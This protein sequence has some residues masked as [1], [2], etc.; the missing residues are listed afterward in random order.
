MRNAG[1]EKAQAGIK[2]A[3]RNINN[4]RYAGDTILM[5]IYHVFFIHSSIDGHLGCFHV[6]ATVNSA[7]VNTGAHVTF[8]IMVFSEYIAQ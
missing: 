2:I 1:L 5:Y 8:S 6:L 4:L 3:G 7:A